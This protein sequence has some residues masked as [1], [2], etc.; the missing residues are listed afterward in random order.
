MFGVGTQEILVILTV[1]LLLF[2]G[3]R[4]PEI[5]RSL[6]KGLGDF[7]RAVNDVQREVDMEIL[8]ETTKLDDPGR[9]PPPPKPEQ[10]TAKRPAAPKAGSSEPAA[11]EA[12]KSKPKPKSG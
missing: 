2:G 10:S 3:K 11:S 8:K 4:I 1:V 5:A 6:G 7:P 12:A 9:R